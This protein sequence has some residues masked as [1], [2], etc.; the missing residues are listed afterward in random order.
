MI[1]RLHYIS[2]KNNQY[3][4]IE[5]IENALI[6]GCKWI[7]LRVKNEPE[8]IVLS[9]AVEAK[10]LCEQYGAKLIINDFPEVAKAIS[11]YGVHLGLLDMPV[12]EARKIVGSDL[13][14]GGTANT[15][16]NILQRIN[17]G[18]DY[19]GLGPYRFTTTKENLSPVLGF[20]GYQKITAKLKA[21]NIET[22]IIAIGGILLS[23]VKSLRELGIHGVAVSGTITY[24][25]NREKVVSEFYDSLNEEAF[26]IQ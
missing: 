12:A 26:F 22:P 18:A 8:N 1:D 20:E 15:Y 3:D 9:Y 21:A 5:A 25:E 24:A 6:S 4:H 7:Q 14:I 16:E 17:D 10:K 13:I 11:A 23:D 2:Q 19:V